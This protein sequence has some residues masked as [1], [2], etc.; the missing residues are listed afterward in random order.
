MK[1]EQNK[2]IENLSNQEVNTDK[3]TGGRKA[4]YEE[5]VHK[6]DLGEQERQVDRK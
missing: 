4:T 3:V 1:K 2:S 5:Q 6:R